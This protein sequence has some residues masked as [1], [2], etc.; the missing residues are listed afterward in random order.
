MNVS[1]VILDRFERDATNNDVIVNYYTNKSKEA[2]TDTLSKP[3]PAIAESA[4]KI[5]KLILAAKLRIIIMSEG[6]DE[7]SY[8][9]EVCVDARRHRK[10][11][12]LRLRKSS[13][14]K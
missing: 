10:E 2:A 11:I 4:N 12:E 14:A 13:Y 5:Q 1:D 3:N 8:G 9:T 6:G 7:K